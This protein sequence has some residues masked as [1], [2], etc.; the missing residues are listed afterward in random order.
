MKDDNTKK[1]RKSTNKELVEE[2]EALN[3]NGKYDR[4]IKRARNNEY[5][6]FKAP[7]DIVCGKVEAVTDLQQFPEL[8]EILNKIISGDYDETPD[9]ED[10]LDMRKDVPPHLWGAFGLD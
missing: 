4:L 3:T 8:G 6:D 1:V 7:G 2:L 9:E 10:K 5:H